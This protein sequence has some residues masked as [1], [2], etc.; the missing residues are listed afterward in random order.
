MKFKHKLLLITTPSIFVLDQL[1]KLAVLKNID[2]GQRV[3]II[4]DFF[5]LVHFRNTGAAFGMFAN[6]ADGF[7]VPFFYG[8]AVVA[9]VVMAFFYKALKND[10]RL[11][12]VAFTFIFGGI[13]GNIVDRIRLGSVVDFLSFHI[14]DAAIDFEIF[15]KNIHILLEWPAF[16]VADSAI[17]IAMFL[18][19]WSALFRKQHD[20]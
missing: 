2:L 5:D 12:P 3:P 15:G 20:S 9:I 16:N 19:G 6:T 10:E 7:R 8:I 18:L 1:T 17:T 13:A 11:L 4:A 14:G